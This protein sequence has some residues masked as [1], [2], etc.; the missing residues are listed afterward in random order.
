MERFYWIKVGIPSGPLMLERRFNF[1]S[2]KHREEFENLAINAGY[3]KIAFG[4]DHM[5]YP[6]EAMTE[7]EIEAESFN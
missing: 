5:M 2:V 3:Q 1:A 4:I 6:T 7:C